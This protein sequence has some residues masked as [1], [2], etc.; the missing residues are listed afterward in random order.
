VSGIIVKSYIIVKYFIKKVKNFCIIY[1]K[2]GQFKV[3][4]DNFFMQLAINEAFKYQFLT[5]PNPA[6]GAVVVKN[7]EILSIE[8]HKK[9][10]TSHAEVLALVSAFET[11][12]GRSVGFD[13]SNAS[14]AHNF[15]LALKKDFFKDCEIYVTLE[16]CS[17]IGKTPSCANLLKELKLKRVYIGTKDPI[18][19][20]SGGIEILKSANIDVKVGILE[21]ENNNLIEPFK[22]WQ[23]RGFVLFKLAQTTNGQIG[24]GYISSKESLT[25]VHKLRSVCTKL[26]IGGNTVRVDRPTLDCRF[27]DAKAPD[28]VIYS[29]DINFDKDISLFKITNRKV[30]IKKSL[31]FLTNRG[32][33]LVE[34]GEGMLNAL[35]NSIDWI[36]IY[37]AP[38]LSSNQLS[39]NINSSLQFLHIDRNSK[40][41]LIWSRFLG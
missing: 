11:I 12:T 18:S 31:D 26:V 33:Y 28:I 3:N 7:G 4:K 39:Y 29:K 20:H 23:K 36:L 21:Q 40:D 17:H 2:L 22:I 6:V 32:F 19:S 38:K 10:G 25:H 5:Y 27:I 13:K 37:Q 24:G 15:L 41:I 35:K 1:K 8:A 30:E 34:G 9:A 16:P 14:K